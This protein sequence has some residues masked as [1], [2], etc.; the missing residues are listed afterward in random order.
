MRR[1][2]PL[3]LFF[4]AA[5]AAA[6]PQGEGVEF[7]EKQVR[8]ILVGRCYPC[9]SDA[10]TKVKGG[11]KLDTRAAVRKGGERGPAII[12]GDPDKSLL[13][14]AVRYADEALRMPPKAKLS[15]AEIQTLETWVRIG[16]PDPRTVAVATAPAPAH[17]TDLWSLRPVQDPP[18]PAVRDA[19]WPQ[20]D[21]DRFLLAAMEAK[22]L[23]PVAVA[24]KRLLIRRAT[25]DLTGLP[26]TPE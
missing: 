21:V 13:V 4:A 7:F 24:D 17:P 14:N 6:A 25:F 8:P 23:K 2:L 15:D 22:G 9:H 16:A 20:N 10:A 11:L 5:P 19:A 18:V 1:L 26:P 3:T 12:P